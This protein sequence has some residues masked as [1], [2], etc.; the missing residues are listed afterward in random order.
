MGTCFCKYIGYDQDCEPTDES[1][2]MID[3]LRGPNNGQYTKY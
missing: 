3:L 2:K 1:L